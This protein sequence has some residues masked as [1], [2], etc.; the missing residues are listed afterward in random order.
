VGAV[1]SKRHEK[2]IF[3]KRIGLSLSKRVRKRI[4]HV[5]IVYDYPCSY[6]PSPYDNWIE[7]SQV[8]DE[9]ARELLRRYGIDELKAFNDKDEQIPVDLNGFVNGCYPAQVFDVCEL[10]CEYLEDKEE[11]AFQQ[12]VN[13][14]LD[15]EEVPW[16]F[17]DGQFFKVDSTFLSEVISHSHELLRQ[18]GC[19]GAIQEFT[20]ARND[21]TSE[22]FKGAIH[23]SCKAFESVLKFVLRE[24]SGNAS[25]LIRKLEGI[26]FFADLP[27]GIAK[28][29]SGQVLMSLPFIR[30]RLSGHGQGEEIMNIPK[31][32]AKLTLHMAAALIQFVIER[33]LAMGNGETQGTVSDGDDDLPF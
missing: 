26:G 15:E 2:L 30:N 9:V 14:V 5:L 31:E 33:S 4:W 3:E 12:N 25:T 21:L 27:E 11:Y 18:V 20:D 8:L 13:R 22:D 23:N 16:R 32:Y 17:A 6:Q 24:E 10:C 28:P 29:F 19:A 1:F 7:N